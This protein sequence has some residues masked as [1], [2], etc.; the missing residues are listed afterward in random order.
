MK[1]GRGLAEEKNIPWRLVRLC[2]LVPSSTTTCDS[3]STDESRGKE[4]DLRPPKTFILKFFVFSSVPV[5]CALLLSRREAMKKNPRRSCSLSS[6]GNSL[7]GTG[8]DNGAPYWMVSGND[9]PCQCNYRR[10]WRVCVRTHTCAGDIRGSSDTLRSRSCS[11]RR[12][13]GGRGDA[14]V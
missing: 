11:L 14:G 5:F 9:L 2:P 13:A 6:A 4:R 10:H 12:P 1:A 3:R 7:S 8:L